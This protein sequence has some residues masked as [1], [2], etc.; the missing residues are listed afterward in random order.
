MLA[1]FVMALAAFVVAIATLVLVCAA[2]MLVCAALVLAFAAR[3]F[4]GLC[5]A[6]ILGA[7]VHAGL[8][9]VS[10]AGGVLASA[11]V[12]AVMLTDHRGVDSA[13]NTLLSGIV[14]A[15]GGH[16]ESKSDS[17]NSG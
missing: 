9:V 10:S 16:T 2:L 13:V 12:V 17:G 3:F 8:A 1:A 6:A 7:P 4:T 11:L 15:A 14:V 5:L